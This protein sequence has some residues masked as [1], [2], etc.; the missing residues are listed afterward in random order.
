MVNNLNIPDH[1]QKMIEE[2]RKKMKELKPEERFIRFYETNKPY[3]CFS[4]FAKN[5]IIIKDKEWAT[6]EHYFQAQKFVGT[7]YEEEIRLVSTPMEA[8]R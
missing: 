5:T 4:N 7:E 1:V 2:N 8:A 3:G 6:T